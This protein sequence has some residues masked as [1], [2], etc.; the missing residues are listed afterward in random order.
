MQNVKRYGMDE[1]EF[2]VHETKTHEVIENVRNHKSEIGIF[3]LNDFNRN[4]LDK[5]FTEYGLQFQ[6]LLEC[7]VYVYMWKGHPLA[8]REEIFGGNSKI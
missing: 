2:E 8:E 5:L 6:P 3:Y 7:G 1:Y 4:V